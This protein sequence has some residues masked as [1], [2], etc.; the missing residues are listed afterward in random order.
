MDESDSGEDESGGS[1]SEDGSAVEES[2]K[3]ESGDD[4]NGEIFKQ[5][6]FIF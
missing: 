2:V 4:I 3:G 6:S 5:T 1:G